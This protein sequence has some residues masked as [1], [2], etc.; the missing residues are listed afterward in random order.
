MYPSSRQLEDSDLAPVIAF[1]P[2]DLRFEPRAVEP[3]Y[4]RPPPCEAPPVRRCANGALARRGDLE[5][6]PFADQSGPIESGLQRARR[7]R[8]VVDRHT[9][10]VPPVDPDL[11]YRASTRPPP[12]KLDEV[13]ADRI[14][15]FLY[16][17]LQ[18]VV[19]APSQPPPPTARTK[20]CGGSPHISTRD[21]D[22]R[23]VGLNLERAEVAVKQAGGRVRFSRVRSPVGDQHTE[24]ALIV[25]R[26]MGVEPRVVTSRTRV[27]EGDVAYS[28]GAHVVGNDRAQ[29]DPARPGWP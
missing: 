14:K 23:A 27:A 26:A 10:T 11:D 2:N 19:H 18:L 28:G 22:S 3:R 4:R 16:N 15:L 7:S 13:E 5:D 24:L 1:E 12:P 9:G 6:V 29:I 21:T 25:P 20:K 17:A 8:A